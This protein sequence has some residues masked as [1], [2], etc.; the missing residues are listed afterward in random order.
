[1]YATSESAHGPR[2]IVG[3]RFNI[4]IAATLIGSLRISID[5]HALYSNTAGT[6]TRSVEVHSNSIFKYTSY[7]TDGLSFFRSGYLLSW[8]YII[9]R[10]TANTKLPVRAMNSLHR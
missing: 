4:S 8:W 10:I 5:L 1:M 9:K 2:K 6:W 3:S 7:T